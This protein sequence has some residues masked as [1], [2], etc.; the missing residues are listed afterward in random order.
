MNERARTIFLTQYSEFLG[1]R[2]EIVRV[3]VWDG[4]ECTISKSRAVPNLD[5]KSN[6]SGSTRAI[7]FARSQQ[8]QTNRRVEIQRIPFEAII[9]IYAKM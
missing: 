1:E 4:R 5:T 3:R 8:I 9:E 6:L 2:D 7:F